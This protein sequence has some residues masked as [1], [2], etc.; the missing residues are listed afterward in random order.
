MP[1]PRARVGAGVR[2]RGAARALC[3]WLPLRLRGVRGKLRRSARRRTVHDMCSRTLSWPPRDHRCTAPLSATAPSECALPLPRVRVCGARTCAAL[4]AD[5]RTSSSYWLSRGHSHVSE[6]PTAA[7]AFSHM[8]HARRAG[9]L[10]PRCRPHALPARHV[11][12]QPQRGVHQ[13]A[14]V[15]AAMRWR[16]PLAITLAAVRPRQIR[17]GATILSALRLG[18][19]RR[20]VLWCI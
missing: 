11:L 13:C 15:R 14:A 3:A 16:W 4:Q 5:V 7:C 19:P 18:L 10:P 12:A 9:H 8:A 20:F 1:R 17:S 6:V 2:K